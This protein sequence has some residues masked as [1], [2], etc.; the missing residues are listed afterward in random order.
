[1]AKWFTAVIDLLA[2]CARLSWAGSGVDLEGAVRSNALETVSLEGYDIDLVV[3]AV[4]K[5][6]SDAARGY[7]LLLLL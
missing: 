6:M 4:T 1:M 2:A 7:Y 3:E 5:A